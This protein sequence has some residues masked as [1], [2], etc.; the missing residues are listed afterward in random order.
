MVDEPRSLWI[1]VLLSDDEEYTVYEA[2]G[3]P[4]QG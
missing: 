3:F 2:G 1:P 4:E